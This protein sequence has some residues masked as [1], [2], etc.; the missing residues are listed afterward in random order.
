MPAHRWRNRRDL[1]LP[2]RLRAPLQARWARWLWPRSLQLRPSPKVGSGSRLCENSARYNR[3]RNFEACGHAQ[4]K[5]MQKFVFRS[6]LRPNQISFSHS[7]GHFPPPSI[8]T[9]MEEVARRPDA[10][11]VNCWHGQVDVP[12]LCHPGDDCSPETGRQCGRPWLR[13]WTIRSPAPFR[14]HRKSV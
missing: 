8:A 6:A 11:E 14:V 1:G 10:N 3:T 2:E 12:A 9:G 7:L 13:R 5:K 4:S